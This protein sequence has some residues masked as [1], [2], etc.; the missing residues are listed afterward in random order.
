MDRFILQKLDEQKLA[1]NPE[2]DRAA[3]LRRVSFVLTGLPPTPEQLAT[4]LGD[5]APNAYEKQVDALLASP[6][7]GERMALDWMEVARFAD[8]F[9][10]QSDN[11]CFVW[12]WR[13]W[14]IRSFNNNLP[15]DQF[16]TWQTAGDLLPDATQ[17]QRLAT[18]FNR[19][20]RQTQE[21]VPSSR[22]SVRNTSPTAFTPPARRFSG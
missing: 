14:V 3:L 22:S 21:G 5:A 9:G 2:A 10:Y 13:D 7:Y 6:R 15:Y 16:V 11:G 19:L 12:P 1:P 17:E 18:T 4:F 8:T 20:H